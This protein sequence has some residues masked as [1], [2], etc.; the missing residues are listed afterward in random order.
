MLSIAT[1]LGVVL[2]IKARAASTRGLQ[3]NYVFTGRDL[4]SYA[5][6]HLPE[7]RDLYC[8]D[9]EKHLCTLDGCLLIET[10][11]T[12]SVS[13]PTRTMYLGTASFCSFDVGDKLEF[14]TTCNNA[15]AKSAVRAV[16][17]HFA[18]KED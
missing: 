3:Q 2:Y 14:F 11:Q 4:S 15:R 12:K 7:L 9:Y 8:L 17:K 1:K 6:T 5:A 10:F 13:L 16:R 18:L